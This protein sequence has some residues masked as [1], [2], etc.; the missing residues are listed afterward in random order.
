MH[1][2]KEST[3]RDPRGGNNSR[4]EDEARPRP[5]LKR[6]SRLHSMFISW[7][8]SSLSTEDS[9]AYVY[10]KLACEWYINNSR[11]YAKTPARQYAAMHQTL[12]KP[13]CKIGMLVK[14]VP[15]MYM[16]NKKAIVNEMADGLLLV[17]LSIQVPWKTI[18]EEAIRF[19]TPVKVKKPKAC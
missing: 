15:G 3:M 17:D 12:L 1:R 8:V 9:L 10:S 11:S 18:E 6:L 5:R 4:W 7:V 14:V 19:S 16:V 13:L 2:A